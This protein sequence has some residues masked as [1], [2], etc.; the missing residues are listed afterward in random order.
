MTRPVRI[1]WST[2]RQATR[3]QTPAGAWRLWRDVWDAG[4]RCWAKVADEAFGSPEEADAAL[5][6]WIGPEQPSTIGTRRETSW[7]AA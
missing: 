3:Y 5:V 4:R 1:E 7:V 2:T 6:T